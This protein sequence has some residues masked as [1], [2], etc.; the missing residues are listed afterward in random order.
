[1]RIFSSLS[2]DFNQ[3]LRQFRKSPGFAVT[4]VAILAAGIGA[5]ATMFTVVDR[6]LL[7]PLPY[8]NPAQLVEIKEA[9]KKGSTMFGAP[10]LDLEAWREGS[11]NLQSIAFHTY[12]K[13]TSFLEGISG[14]VQVNTPHVSTN[15]FTTLGVSPVIG[16][17]FSDSDKQQIDYKTAVLSNTVWR[18]GFGAD[19][20]ILGKVIKVNGN[21]YTVIGV[22]PRGFQ[23]PFNPEKPQIWIPIQVGDRDQVRV[24]NA[25]PEYR[26]IARLRK[27]ASISAA[28]AE[29]KV[30]QADIAKLYTDPVA[31]EDATS[32]E[33]Y[34]YGDSVVNGNVQE[35]LLALL[36]AAIAL[37][38]IACVN[39]TS[40][41]LARGAAKQREIAVRAALGASHWRITRQLLIEG[42]LLSGVACVFSLGLVFAALRMF[43]NELTAYVNVRF[44][45]T[46]NIALLFFLLALTV[47]SAVIS[48]VWPS[49][50]AAK[51]SIDPVLKQGGQYVGQSQHRARKILVASQVAISFV[52]LSSCGLLLRTIFVLKHVSPG[53]NTDH[54]IVADMVVPAYKFDGKNMTTELYQPLVERVEHMPGVEAASLTT[55]VP[56]GKRFPMLFTLA[57]DE[58]DP[59]SAQTENLVAQFR[60]VGPGL[61]RVLGFRMLAGKFFN[62]NDTAGSEPV[63]VV[64]RV[65][66]KAFFGDNR[67]PGKILGKELLS[68]GNDKPA[69]IIGVLDDERQVSLLEESKPEID[70]CIPQITPKTGFYRVAEGLAMNLAVRTERN[71]NAFIPELRGI[72]ASASPE[73][74]GSTF[75]TMDE[76]VDDSFGDQRMASQLLQLFAGSALL[77]CVTG[78]YSTLTYFVTQRTRELGI[79]FALG[80]QQHQ[81]IW[82]IMRQAGA[83]L[84]LG[85]AVG[86]LISFFA[87]RILRNIIFGV[88]TYDALALTATSLILIASGLAAAYLPAR[89]AARVD[90]MQALRTE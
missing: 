28:T 83:V 30:V 51:T 2:A 75:K 87:N 21:S 89:R 38:L 78:L 27:G 41:M 77:L 31:R 82:L 15:L 60:A 52:L 5:S 3:S 55:A 48:S 7:R 53:F 13:P 54:V 45:G 26:I 88:K 72:L 23:F 49:L 47:G 18:D 42:L 9:G 12:D 66:V 32:V 16:H 79:R 37:W 39:V 6:V 19:P 90:P 20:Q 17:G 86:L 65:F 59:Q 43:E 70:V 56:L 57:A 4:V 34:V 67:D 58:S 40:L 35:A 76:V 68:Y 64:N 24:K 33:M 8:N 1:L 80:A 61:Q 81:A 22:M 73:L 46:P 85:S 11:H 14:P 84:L 10:Y 74:A 50:V 62:E 29:L 71:P 63:L 36:V 69:H 25:T 44:E